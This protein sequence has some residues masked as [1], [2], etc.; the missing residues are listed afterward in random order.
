MNRSKMTNIWLR[1]AEGRSAQCYGLD[2]QTWTDSDYVL[3]GWA[4]TAP[5][6]MGYDKVDFLVTW[7]DGETYEGRFDMKYEHKLEENLLGR[8]ITDVLMFYAGEN[9]P[10]YMKEQAYREYVEHYAD[11]KVAYLAFLEEHDLGM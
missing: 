8:Q 3:R 10:D 7:E 9:K 4:V 1:R 2:V 11:M 5:K 6:E